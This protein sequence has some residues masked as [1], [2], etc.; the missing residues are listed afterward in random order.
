VIH[1]YGSFETKQ[2]TLVEVL[3]LLKRLSPCAKSHRRE[4]WNWVWNWF[5]TGLEL[6]WNWEGSLELGKHRGWLAV[7]SEAYVN[8]PNRPSLCLKATEGVPSDP[9]Y[10]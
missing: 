9:V 1:T 7:V 10:V 3:F 4:V 8:R 6:D 2:T 5:G